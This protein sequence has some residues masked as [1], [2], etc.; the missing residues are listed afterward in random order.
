M[1]GLEYTWWFM[2]IIITLQI[3]SCTEQL[4]QQDIVRELREIKMELKK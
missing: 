2:A 1:K 4:R 3:N